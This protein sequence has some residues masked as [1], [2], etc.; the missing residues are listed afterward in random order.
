LNIEESDFDEAM[1]NLLYDNYGSKNLISK[2]VN[3]QIYL[4]D[5]LIKSLGIDL[6]E[7][8]ITLISFLNSLDYID[9]VYTSKE[10]IEGNFLDGYELLIQNGYHIQRS[11]DLIFKFKPNVFKYGKRGTSHGSGYHYDTHVPLIF[12]GKK[13]KKG[14]SSKRTK[15]TDI[16]PTI[17][18]IM[19]NKMVTTT[20]EV[21]NYVIK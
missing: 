11:G 1:E 3:N 18:K 15:I 8:T 16:A 19:G 20:G 21:L 10:I 13:I 17:A 9:G 5:G 4:N 14:E 7:V 6:D 2:I 12:Y